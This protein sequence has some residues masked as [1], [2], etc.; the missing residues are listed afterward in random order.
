MTRAKTT[1]IPTVLIILGATGDLMTRK[2]A[3]TLYHMFGNGSLPNMFK[4]VGVAR[5]E[6]SNS[7][8]RDFLSEH[9]KKRTRIN[10]NKLNSFLNKV[11]YNKGF[12]EKT[13]TYSNLKKTVRE[14]DDQWGV[15]ANKLFY[16][17]VPPKFYETIFNSL[18]SSGLADPCSPEEGWTRII[19]EKPFGEDYKTAKKLD[20]L[21]SKLFKEIQIYRIDHYLAKEMV[22]N[23]LSFRFSNTL[24]EKIW[25]KEFVGR[26]DIRLLEKHGVEDR[27]A[28]YDSIGALRDMGQNH[29]LQMLALTTM[30]HPESF[31]SDPIRFKR[32]SILKTLRPP[33]KS[34]IKKY[35]Y[36]AQ[37]DGYKDIED[38]KKSS[39]TETYFKIGGAFLT[40]PRWS[41]IPIT[42]ES[43]KRMGT[44]EKEIVITFKHPIPCLCPQGATHYENKI[45]FQLEPEEVISVQFWA[46]KPGTTFDI[47]ERDLEFRLRKNNKK[48]QYVEEYEKLLLDVIAG[49]QTLFITTDEVHAM[50][51]FTD[52]I[53]KAWQKGTTKLHTYRPN[54][55]EPLEK[56]S[57]T[58]SLTGFALKPVEIK[59]GMKG[60]IGIIGLGRMGGNIG[61]HLV[62]EGWRVVGSDKNRELLSELEHE[63]IET[64]SSMKDLTEKLPKK[65]IIW[66]MLPAGRVVDETIEKLIPLLKANDTIIDGG[67][68][69]F[70]DSVK[71]EKKLSKKGI[72][73]IDVGVSGGPVAA[74]DGASLMIGGRRAQFV[75]LEQLFKDLAHNGSYEFFEGVGAGH[76]V[77]MIHNGIEYGMMQSIAEG[78]NILKHSQYSLN[79]KKIA[80]VY[81]SG[82]VIESKLMGWLNDAFKLHGEDLKGVSG[83]VSQSGEGQWT[84][85]IAKEKKL[86]V[87]IIEESLKFRK[88]SQ[89][90]PN[91]TGKILSALRE[92][93]GGHSA[94]KER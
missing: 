49:D 82:A 45:M 57:L 19:V 34:E 42:L 18:S 7:D 91:Y 58:D 3:P 20:E 43:G 76:F 88:L 63:G 2:I 78:F 66:L 72:N 36:R 23:I 59:S 80:A 28:Y 14:I 71:R 65:K 44:A 64:A 25:N 22:Q 50:W 21:L 55:N 81:N 47:E 77:K 85:D 4:V 56:S 67:N 74:L 27:G 41:G 13:I 9:I 60:A 87:K 8:Y 33:L 73:F 6:L 61:K 94:R 15:C 29:I 17:A 24:F 31:E 16:L 92:Q 54:T 26:I 84:I 70:K 35:S 93:F 37:Y 30:D 48:T 10:S 90:S 86:K 53:V 46:K 5:R 52:P 38:V 79:L 12:F 83:K 89:K 11:S 68:S 75:K 51:R 32:A 69:F 39:K 40:S 62:R 1:N